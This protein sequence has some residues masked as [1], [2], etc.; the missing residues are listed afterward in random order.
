MKLSVQIVDCAFGIAADNVRV[1]LSRRVRSDWRRVAERR[2]DSD[3]SL[4]E[5]HDDTLPTG[6]YRIE[7]NLER[8]YADAGITPFFP[9]VTFEF[10]LVDTTSDLLIPVLVTGNS[11]FVC[12]SRH[13]SGVPPSAGSAAPGWSASSP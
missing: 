3:G 6:T 4:R 2:T 5:W 9:R 8:Y 12:R 1:C 10:D 11:Y 7:V 13:P